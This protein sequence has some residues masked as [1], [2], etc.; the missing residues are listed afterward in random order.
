MVNAGWSTEIID[1]GVAGTNVS[2]IDLTYHPSTRT[3]TLDASSNAAMTDAS[4]TEI[5]A[6][7]VPDPALDSIVG[8]T[9]HQLN[10]ELGPFFTQTFADYD[11]MDLGT[12]IYHPVGSTDQEMVSNAQSPVPA[13]NG[14][15]DLAADAVRSVPTASSRRLWPRWGAI[16]GTLPRTI[17][18]RSRWA[19]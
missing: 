4:L 17:S 16:L 7:P 3:T 18:R 5:D 15:G 10:T 11:P 6:D 9:D 13:P 8:F 19:R 1:A 2:R 12:G 14:L